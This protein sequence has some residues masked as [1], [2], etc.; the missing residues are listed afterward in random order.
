MISI[1]IT[2]KQANKYM[3]EL[4]LMVDEI[5]EKGAGEINDGD[6]VLTHCHSGHVMEIL[7][8]AKRKGKKF[9]V[10]VTETRPRDQGVLSAKELL[11][12]GIKVTYCVDSAFGF[13][14]KRVTRMLVGCDAILA[15]GSVV[16]KIGTFPMALVAKRFNVPVLVA[17]GT[18]EFVLTPL[19]SAG[20]AATVAW[21]FSP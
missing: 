1:G 8:R 6:V 2:A 7:K 19:G 12:A 16:N 3:D 21:T 4:K 10:I 9:E 11:G 13:V 18:Y 14:M 15:D 20:G 5:A 17:G